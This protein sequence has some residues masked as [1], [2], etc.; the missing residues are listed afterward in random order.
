LTALGKFGMIT[1]SLNRA[2]YFN[3]S[4]TDSPGKCPASSPGGFKRIELRGWESAT[5]PP[6][7][8]LNKT[9]IPP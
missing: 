7:K 4:I 1:L 3:T 6:Y 8:K 9:K 2:I 5:P